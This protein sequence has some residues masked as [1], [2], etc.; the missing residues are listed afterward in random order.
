[1]K[2]FKTILFASMLLVATSCSTIMNGSKDD[3]NVTSNPSSATVF[4]NNQELGPT[5]A[6]LKLQRGETH[7][8]EVKKP[9]YQ[10]YRITTSKEIAGWFWGNLLCG[11]VVGGAIDL[12]TGNAYD[13]EPKFINATLNK[14]NAMNK[15]YDLENINGIHL[16][17]ADGNNLGDIKIVWE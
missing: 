8:I 11:G 13:I 3:V 2:S 15:F 4:V 17:D 9:G 12:I 6:L 1:M 14:D 5:P 10:V 16:T 7:V